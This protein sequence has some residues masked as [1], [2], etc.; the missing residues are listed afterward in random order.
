L[1]EEI[2]AIKKR[3]GGSIITVYDGSFKRPAGP[4]FV[5]IFTT[6]SP[7]VVMEDA[8]AKVKVG[9]IECNGH[10]ISV[11][12]SEVAVALDR[13]FDQ[14]IPEAKLSS[15]RSALLEVL[16]KRFQEVLNGQRSLDTRLGQRLFGFSSATAGA[17][18]GDLSLPAS[19]CVLNNEQIEAIRAAC[20]S[21][22]HFIWGPPGTGKTRIT[23]G[24]LIAVLLRR[25]LRVLV[26][27]HTTLRRTTR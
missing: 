12:G 6:E 17:D 27:S 16:R 15:D 2:E 18:A 4:F 21:D 10:I 5:Y 20:G 23:I 14:T 11:Q 1:A 25:N 22:V 8:E 19:D 3:K 26:V 7:L 24:F 13:Y 9:D